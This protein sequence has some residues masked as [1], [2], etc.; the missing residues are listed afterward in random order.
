MDWFVPHHFPLLTS[1]VCAV[2]TPPLSLLSLSS[3]I[4]SE[5][6]H[7]T[8]VLNG[9]LLRIQLNYSVI[10]LPWHVFWGGYGAYSVLELILH[11]SDS[12]FLG[13]QSQ[14][15]GSSWLYSP[16]NP[17]DKH[18]TLCTSLVRP[19]WSLAK[20]HSIWFD[21]IDPTLTRE[22]QGTLPSWP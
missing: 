17:C 4:S 1:S 13:W 5:K 7:L 9:L 14:I 21:L 8:Y 18:F 3:S 16:K 19:L 2:V 6:P 10:L 15:N 22:C 12:T 11:P 20:P